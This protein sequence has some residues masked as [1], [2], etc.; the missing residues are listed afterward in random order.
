[1]HRDM[2]TSALCADALDP[3]ALLACICESA[4]GA[5]ASFTGH[6]R[7][8]DGISGLFLEHHP[9][10]A[11]QQLDAIVKHAANNWSLEAASAMHRIGHVA[12]GA[13]IVFVAAASAHRAAALAA[14]A[15]IIDSIKTDVALWK[16]EH[17]TSGQTRW[18]QPRDSDRESTAAW[19]KPPAT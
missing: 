13:P 1:M 15:Y 8:D 17:L 7:A 10:M 11:A 19:H 2:F 4:S 18:V 12:T 5:V 16:R 14:C 6:V 3:A 9:Q